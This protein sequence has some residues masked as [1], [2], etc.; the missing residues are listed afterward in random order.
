MPLHDVSKRNGA[1]KIKSSSH[2]NGVCEVKNNI[3]GTHSKQLIID[4]SICNGYDTVNVEAKFGDVIFMN[5]A[6]I[7]ASGENLSDDFRYTII[8]RAHNMMSE[9][10]LPGK[11]DIT[12]NKFAIRN[13]QKRYMNDEKAEKVLKIMGNL[14]KSHDNS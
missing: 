4:E 6:L 2:H 13:L 9:D 12:H 3:V 1:L 5:N 7:H 10:F 8:S 11:I 14:T